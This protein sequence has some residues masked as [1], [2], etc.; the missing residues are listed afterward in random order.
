LRKIKTAYEKKVN[1]IAIMEQGYCNNGE[2][3]KF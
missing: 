3:V 2:K 1:M